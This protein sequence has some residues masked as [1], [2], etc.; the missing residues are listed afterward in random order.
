MGGLRP[1]GVRVSPPLCL[2]SAFTEYF[3]AIMDSVCCCAGR[4]SQWLFRTVR[5][6]VALA[7]CCVMP[8]FCGGAGGCDC[9]DGKAAVVVSGGDA[10]DGPGGTVVATE[11]TKTAAVP[12]G[13]RLRQ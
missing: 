5:A 10:G 12:R 1:F 9:V 2:A 6:S 13:R 11:L 7:R 4:W 8:S 3:V